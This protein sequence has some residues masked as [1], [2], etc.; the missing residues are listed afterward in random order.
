MT[1]RSVQIWF[2]NRRQRLKPMQPK[3]SGVG[4]AIGG[5]HCLTVPPT[6]TSAG[7]T[8]N[9]SNTAAAA[10]HQQRQRQQQAATFQQNLSVASL[11]AATGA[12]LANGATAGGFESLVLGHAMN[13]L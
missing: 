12:A 11:A 2:Q 8:L 13:Q 4:Q 9:T 10:Q 1:P 7:S 5:G 3:P 6:R